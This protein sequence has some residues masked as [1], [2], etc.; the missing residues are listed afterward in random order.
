MTSQAEINK[1]AERYPF[2]DEE[3]EQLIRC[4]SALCDIKNT[5]SF[6][7]KIALSSPYSYFFLPG[8]EMR[9]RIEIV[10]GRILP[11]G[12]GSCLRAAMSVDLFVDCANEGQDLSLERFLEGVA[13]CGQRGHKEA[14]RVIWDCC[15]YLAGFADALKPSLI[16]DLCYRLAFAADVTISPEA[17]AKSIIEKLESERDGACLSLEKSLA[18]F[19]KTDLIDKQNFMTWA[20]L[21]VPQ[22][23]STLSTFVHNLLFHTKWTR[24]H[25]NFVPFEYPKLDHM[26]SIFV[27]RHCSNL[28]AL[29]LTSPLMGGKWHNLYSFEYHGNSMNRLQYSILGFS[30]PSVMVIE[31]EQGHILGAFLNTTWKKS[32]EFYGDS[33]AFIFQLHPTLAVFNPTGNETNFVHLLDGLGFG[34]TKDMPRLYIPASMEACNAGVMDKTFREGDLLPGDALEKF[35]IKSLEVWA[36]GGDDVIRNGL[37][38]RG[39]WRALTD[40]TIYQARVIKDKSSLVKDINLLDTSLYKH[41]SEARGR[42]EFRVDEKH[43]GYVL[44]RSQ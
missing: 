37:K 9:R 5:D 14:L 24:H 19:G 7:T 3:L 41:L 11:E 44:D 32:K 25:L 18:Q 27:G 10:E 40:S 4:H 2:V 43:G 38:A 23:S 12:F 35:D 16:V 15:S 29:A 42:A 8:N 36:V 21:M 33:N 30:G 6:L 26:S 20:E 39:D 13:D 1:L 17:D 22:L 31:T 28:F 34:G